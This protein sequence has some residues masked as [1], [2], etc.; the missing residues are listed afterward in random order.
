[1]LQELD[2]DYQV[3]RGIY[4]VEKNGSR[5]F[6]GY[7]DQQNV[8]LNSTD[9]FASQGDYSG[10]TFTAGNSRNLRKNNMGNEQRVYFFA[11]QAGQLEIYRGDALLLTRVVKQGEQSISYDELPTGSYTINLRLRQGTQIL[12]EQSVLIV[13]QNNFNLAVKDFDYRLDAGKLDDVTLSEDN[14]PIDFKK[15]YS[16]YYGRAALNYRPSESLMLGYGAAGNSEEL[17]GF[18]GGTFSLTD[19]AQLQYQ[20]SISSE[21]ST[22]YAANVSIYGLHFSYN[23][24]NHEN[25]DRNQYTLMQRIYGLDDSKEY[26]VTMGARLLGGN[27]F[28]SV[29]SNENKDRYTQEIDKYQNMSASWSRDALGGQLTLSTGVNKIEG[30]DKNV[31]FGLSW[32]FD[33]TDNLSTRLQTNT[34]NN[35]GQSHLANL[36]Y[37][38]DGDNWS[39]S[40]T[41]GIQQANATHTHGHLSTTADYQN[42][43][44][45]YDAYAYV[46]TGRNASVSGSI[47][48][49]Q[50]VSGEGLSLTNKR[51]ESFVEV[52]TTWSSP[53]PN[54][55]EIQLDTRV[56]QNSWRAQKMN[57][58]DADILPIS[59][60]S[61]N[62]YRFYTESSQAVTDAT[63]HTFL[64]LP[65]SFY[66]INQ[67][68]TPL[69]E[70]IFVLNNIDGSPGES[71]QCVEDSC[72]GVEPVT[73]D[74]VIRVKYEIGKSIRL[75]SDDLSCLYDANKLG[76]DVVQAYCLPGFNQKTN[77]KSNVVYVNDKGFQFL[78]E[79]PITNKIHGLIKQLD[80]QKLTLK[81][82]ELN[83]SAYIYLPDSTKYSVSQN[84]LLAELTALKRQS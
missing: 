22:A 25:T 53:S 81:T 57:A 21:N 41:A 51:G 65:G 36:T 61:E 71:A 55:E 54:I 19:S 8:A 35:Q 50:I 74:G 26:G 20:Q 7:V 37:Q 44:F 13:N 82:I 16:P 30:Q 9:F 23:A 4:D 29:F 24:V 66:S 31:S 18:Y 60:Y 69:K 62:S 40:T 48:G 76:E 5:A 43:Y 56:D 59:K 32:S 2:K 79:F 49:T 39:S 3:Q 68:I 45:D 6:F 77:K 63:T 11:P 42:D 14:V 28:V 70:Q 84:R 64:G 33:F 46:D 38:Q 52:G 12:S 47:S 72:T 34:S 15:K 27:S 80:K 10:L 75:M 58:G 83:D 17:I 73:D 1:M 78:G 67:Q